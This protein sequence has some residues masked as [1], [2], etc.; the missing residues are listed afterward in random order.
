MPESRPSPEPPPSPVPGRGQ[1]LGEIG[2]QRLRASWVLKAAAVSAFM[3]WG[4]LIAL[5]IAGKLP[6]GH[7]AMVAVMSLASWFFFFWWLPVIDSTIERL[8]GDP[9]RRAIGSLLEAIAIGCVVLVHA[10]MAII[11]VYAAR[12]SSP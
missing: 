7:A 5:A 4:G 8:G 1:R 10:L 9:R 11:V 3:G 2:L 12:S 6:F